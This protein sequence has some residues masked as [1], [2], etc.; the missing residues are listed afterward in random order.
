MPKFFCFYRNIFNVCFLHAITFPYFQNNN[1]LGVLNVL[2]ES[3]CSTLRTVCFDLYCNSI[4]DNKMLSVKS[5]V[6]KGYSILK[7][8]EHNIYEIGFLFIYR[9]KQHDI[10]RV[11]FADCL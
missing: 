10:K 9:A 7:G 5:L 1:I 8:W 2:S 3:K 11:Y 4:K 6:N